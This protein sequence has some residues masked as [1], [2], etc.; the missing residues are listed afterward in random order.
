MGS[1][2]SHTIQLSKGGTEAKV[3]FVRPNDK[4]ADPESSM[5]ITPAAEQAKEYDKDGAAFV[6]ADSLLG[7]RVGTDKPAAQALLAELKTA[8]LQ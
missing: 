4:P 5:T 2:D 6:D 1:M 8:L 3:T 7:V